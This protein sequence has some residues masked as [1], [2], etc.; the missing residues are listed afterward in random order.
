MRYSGRHL[1]AV[2]FQSIEVTLEAALADAVFGA[3]NM[4]NTLAADSKE[5][6]GPE[7]SGRVVVGAYKVGGQIFERAVEQ[8]QRRVALLDHAQRL[9]ARLAASDDQRVK[10]VGQHLLDLFAFEIGVLL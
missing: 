3:A 4:G 5:V 9:G 2:L 10:T 6:F 8:D 7:S 1:H